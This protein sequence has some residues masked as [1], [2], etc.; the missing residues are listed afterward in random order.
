MFFNTSIFVLIQTL[1]LCTHGV[2]VCFSYIEQ[3]EWPAGSAACFPA[4]GER[5]GDQCW[6]TRHTV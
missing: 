4:C 6:C 2:L 5:A 3:A 1:P